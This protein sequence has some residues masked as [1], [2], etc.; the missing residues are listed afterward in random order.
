MLKK[1]EQQEKQIWDDYFKEAL[2]GA[3]QE[4][5]NSNLWWTISERDT[6]NIVKELFD[7]KPFSV[8]E[9]GCGSGGSSFSLV[10][11][12]NVTELHLM[13][14]STNALEYAKKIALKDI[15]IPITYEQTSILSNPNIKQRY[16]FIWNTGLIEHY[17]IDDII[18][19]V[20]NML[21]IAKDNG[22]VMVGIPNKSSMAVCKAR[23]LGSKF[24]S[25]YLKFI[26]GYR[27]TTEIPYS[28]KQIKRVLLTNFED[29]NIDVRFAG[30]PLF[31]GTPEFIVKIADILV[32]CPRN[33]FLSYFII[34][35]GLQ[36]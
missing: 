24:G 28:N 35:K 10:Q 32:K 15:K 4:M 30:S 19:I 6:I 33:A 31:V 12:M 18:T 27:N 11:E 1:V 20:R 13:D 2:S 36:K 21:N 3:G 29:Y 26:P 14:I 22:I 5:E 16:D 9:A 7:Q 8:C 17:Q 25:K 34:K 23:I